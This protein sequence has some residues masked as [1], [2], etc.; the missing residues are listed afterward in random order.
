MLTRI[1]SIIIIIKHNKMQ[2]IAI[3]MLNSQAKNW[4]CIDYVE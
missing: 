1:L 3:I 2:N 4:I